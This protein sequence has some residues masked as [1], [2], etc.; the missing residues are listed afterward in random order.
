MRVSYTRRCSCYNDQNTF[1]HQQSHVPPQH[2]RL[3]YLPS[4]AKYTCTLYP[5]QTAPPILNTLLPLPGV[6]V[7]VTGLSG[8]LRTTSK[9]Q[10]NTMHGWACHFYSSF[11]LSTRLDVILSPTS[12]ITFSI[13]IYSNFHNKNK[14]QS[15]TTI[16]SE[17]IWQVLL[18]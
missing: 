15:P 1:K 5:D 14:N 6:P 13:F 8:L 17:K 16:Q 3:T 4:V 10:I 7:G 2:C 11:V 9:V 18:S 12:P